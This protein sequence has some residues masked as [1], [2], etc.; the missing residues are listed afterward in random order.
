ML[1]SYTPIIQ[2]S[3]LVE[4]YH[5]HSR[6]LSSLFRYRGIPNTKLVWHFNGEHK[7]QL[8]NSGVFKWCPKTIPKIFKISGSDLEVFMVRGS[9]Y[10]MSNV[11]IWIVTV[12]YM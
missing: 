3:P 4:H 1:G 12:P 10:R 5:Y 2:F 11:R 9:E 8:E 6:N 7:V